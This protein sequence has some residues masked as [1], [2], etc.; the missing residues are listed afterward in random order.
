MPTAETS[1]T[2][3]VRGLP[4]SL[5]FLSPLS[6]NCDRRLRLLRRLLF[7]G[8]FLVVSSCLS[9]PPS[10]LSPSSSCLC[11][12]CDSSGR[13]GTR[14]PTKS[15]PNGDSLIFLSVCGALFVMLLCRRGCAWSVKIPPCVG[16][17]AAFAA[18]VAAIRRRLAMARPVAPNRESRRAL[19]SNSSRMRFRSVSP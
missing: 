14:A 6:S 4:S 13:G 9:S 5:A 2:V 18:A 1:P 19:S 3:A 10:P 16:T 17:T 15:L 8:V 11:G 12:N 7:R